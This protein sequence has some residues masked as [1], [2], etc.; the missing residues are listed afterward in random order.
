MGA[1]RSRISAP[2]TASTGPVLAAATAVL[3]AATLLVVAGPAQARPTLPAPIGQDPIVPG[4]GYTGDFPDPHVIRIGKR[5]VAYSTTSYGLNLPVVYST[6][7]VRWQVPPATAATPASDALPR[8]PAWSAGKELSDG[9]FRATSWAPAVAKIGSRFVLAYA[10]QV[11]GRPGRM[12]CIS[13][14]SAT[15]AY[16]PFVDSSAGPLICPPQGA[17]DPQIFKAP[18]GRHWLLWKLDRYPARIY[19]SRMNKTATGL[20]KKPKT[21]F[22]AKVKQSWEGSIV[23]NP[24]MIRFKKK[25]YLFYSANSYASTRYAVGYMICKKWT[26]PCKRPRKKP[27]LRTKGSIA[28]PGGAAAFKDA[29]GR[30]RLA[31]HA[32]TRDRVGYPSDDSCLQTDAGCGQRRLRIATLKVKPHTKGRLQVK[33][34]Y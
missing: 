16:G 11:A 5:Y 12:M 4:Q 28:G 13:L 2:L 15:S 31:Y 8:T 10:T 1:M 29:R 18:S 7:L 6:D 21:T 33:R 3:L 34:W 20:A 25:Y 30:L 14:A 26:G 27:L 22:L 24:S 19:V 17:I 23:E 32:W 9:R